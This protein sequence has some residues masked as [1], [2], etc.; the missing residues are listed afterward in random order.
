[1]AEPRIVLQNEF[2]TITHDADT[3][4]IV[5]KRNGMPIPFGEDSAR[6]HA[7]IEAA[8]SAFDPKCT[9]IL[10]DMRDAPLKSDEVYQQ[11]AKRLRARLVA[12]FPVCAELVRTAVGKL[13]MARLAREQGEQSNAFFSEVEARAY[14]LNR[15][16][17]R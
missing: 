17:Q 9:G 7:R 15:L 1:M 13:Q 4:V 10:F 8:L 2:V 14:L 5:F 6:V 11:G 16:R 12:K 3:S